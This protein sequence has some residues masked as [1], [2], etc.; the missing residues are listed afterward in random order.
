M[1]RDFGALELV[2]EGPRRGHLG[3]ER[4]ARGDSGS[5]AEAEHAAK[6]QALIDPQRSR[7]HYDHRYASS[8]LATIPSDGLLHHIDVTRR[9]TAGTLSWRCVPVEDEQVYRIVALKNPLESPLLSGPIE[10]FVEGSFLLATRQPHVDVGG[11]LEVGLGVDER[12]RV[13][14]NVRT[15]EE[16]QGLLGGKTT[17]EHVVTTELVSQLDFEATVQVIDRV[18]VSR[19]EQIQVKEYEHEPA[20]RA[21]TQRKLERP[22]E[23]GRCWTVALKPGGRRTITSRYTITLGTKYELQGG[24]RRD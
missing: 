16:Q 23:G 12:V 18:P 13:A 7:G 5:L 4:R 19:D 6:A 11:R 24:N 9:E 2:V 17:I 20:A 8:A 22:V 15:Q 14:R 3:A 1:W 21:Y 10:I